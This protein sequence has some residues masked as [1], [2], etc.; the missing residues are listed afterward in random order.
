MVTEVV[1]SVRKAICALDFILDILACIQVGLH[2]Y[3]ICGKKTDNMC[4]LLHNDRKRS[5]YNSC[6]LCNVCSHMCMCV[7]AYMISGM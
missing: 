7:F 5:R 3:K 6:L 4:L 1:V 2:K